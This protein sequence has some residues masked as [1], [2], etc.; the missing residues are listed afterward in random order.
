MPPIRAALEVVVAVELVVDVVV[1]TQPRRKPPVV[2]QPPPRATK[3]WAERHFA[4]G[5]GFWE[6]NVFRSLVYFNSGEWGKVGHVE[7]RQRLAHCLLTLGKLAWGE[8]P[9]DEEEQCSAC[10]DE[11]ES[12]VCKL[13][14]FEAYKNEKHQCGYCGV[15]G[16]WYCSTC[17]PGVSDIQ[18][19]ICNPSTKRE[20]EASKCFAKHV[21]G[22]QAKNHA[23]VH[24]AKSPRLLEKRKAREERQ[25][26][27]D[28]EDDE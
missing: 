2:Q 13:E 1:A 12:H 9:Q 17:F 22:F 23:E 26:W 10:D 3:D 25:R 19:G 11:D 4:E 27:R 20:G 14:R 24:Q 16:Y 8:L 5:L 6:V 18:Y 28:T 7:F 21:L 15:R